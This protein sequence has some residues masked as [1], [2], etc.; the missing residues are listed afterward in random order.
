M[1]YFIFLFLFCF[2]CL[3]MAE[4]ATWLLVDTQKKIIQVKQGKHILE[5]FDK[6]SI[7]RKGA[8]YKQRSGDDITPL[9]NY[10]IAYINDQSN[11]RVFFGLNYPSVY[12][13]ELALIDKRI[14]VLEFQEIKQAHESN[15]LP[16]QNTVLG[17][18]IGIHGIGQG[19]KKVHGVFDWTQG[20]VA[21]SNPQI[22]KLAKL[23]YQGMRVQI[24]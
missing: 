12:D 6:I 24:K 15:S 3:S 18:Y 10:K 22:D 21:V 2:T 23:I 13:A 14:S 19:D 1:R 9:G 4:D 11:F 5:S 16:P 7:G 8:N 20:C 17:G